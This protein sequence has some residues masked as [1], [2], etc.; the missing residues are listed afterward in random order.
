MLLPHVTTYLRMLLLLVTLFVQASHAASACVCLR[1][2]LPHVVASACVC[3]RMCLH[4]H[5]F[6]SET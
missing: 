3:L 2:L 6:A 4:P 1:M 5:V